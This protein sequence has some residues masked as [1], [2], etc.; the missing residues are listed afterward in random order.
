MNILV[1]MPI[2]DGKVPAEVVKALLMERTAAQLLGDDLIIEFLSGCSHPGLGRNQLAQAFMDSPHERLI[3][4]DSD[5]TWEVGQLVKL[6]HYPTDFVGACYRYKKDEEEYPIHW[7]PDPENKGL[8]SNE[9]GLIEVAALPGGFMSLSRNVFEKLK[10]AH[11][12]REFDHMGHKMHCYFEM[13][14]INSRLSGED[15]FFC[16]SW[17][18]IG[19]KIYL[20]PMI[21]LTHWDFKPVPYK[22]NIGNWL[23]SRPPEPEAT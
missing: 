10:A 6:A 21:A 12:D 11:P 13:P 23:R 16:K 8:Y 15:G 17:C 18:D 20:D 2:Y 7:L 9:F 19:G 1:A 3:F 22:G 4:L 14:F 5:V